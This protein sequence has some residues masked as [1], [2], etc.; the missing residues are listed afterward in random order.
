M[1]SWSAVGKQTQVCRGRP[2]HVN[3]S[4]TWAQCRVSWFLTCTCDALVF[5]QEEHIRSTKWPGSVKFIIKCSIS[6]PVLCRNAGHCA[7][8]CCSTNVTVRTSTHR[9]QAA[10]RTPSTQ[11]SRRSWPWWAELPPDTRHPQRVD[12]NQ[13]RWCENSFQDLNSTDCNV[14][15]LQGRWCENSFQD[16]NSTDCN[17]GRLQ[18]RWCQNS[19]QDLNSTDCNVGRLQGRWCQNS[20]QDLNSTDYSVAWLQGRWC[21]NSFHDL[22]S[23]D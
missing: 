16:L 2:D 13:G 18:G 10:R 6:A 22:N 17:V 1:Y 8:L 21:E 15:R 19:F 23:T 9:R 11:L 20:F 5:C 14:G 3:A 7:E 12:S 4:H